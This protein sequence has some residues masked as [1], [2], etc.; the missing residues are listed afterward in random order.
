MKRDPRFNFGQKNNQEEI[1]RDEWGT[2]FIYCRTVQ[3]VEILKEKLSKVQ[4]V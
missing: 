2:T 3:D 4:T 1:D